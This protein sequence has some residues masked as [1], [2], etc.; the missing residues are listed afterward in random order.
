MDRTTLTDAWEAT[1]AHVADTKTPGIDYGNVE[2][3][4]AFL[5]CLEG[6][7]RGAN[8]AAGAAR[9]AGAGGGALGEVGKG[10]LLG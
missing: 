2:K 10:D 6:G 8:A 7:T 5:C 4:L 9:L 3:D 1:A